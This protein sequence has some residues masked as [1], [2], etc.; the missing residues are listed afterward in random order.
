MAIA[1][2]KS[3]MI[4]NPPR[5]HLHKDQMRWKTTLKPSKSS[6]VSRNGLDVVLYLPISLKSISTAVSLEQV[7]DIP[8]RWFILPEYRKKKYGQNVHEVEFQRSNIDPL[9]TLWTPAPVTPLALFEQAPIKYQP[10]EIDPPTAPAFI[11]PALPPQL[12]RPTP[13]TTSATRLL[14]PFLV[15][16]NTMD[17][18]SSIELRPQQY[19]YPPLTP[20]SPTPVM[21]TKTAAPPIAPVLCSSLPMIVTALAPATISSRLPTVVKP[22]PKPTSKTSFMLPPPTPKLWAKVSTHSKAA[23]EAATEPKDLDCSRCSYE[24][25]RAMHLQAEK[26]KAV[27]TSTSSKAVSTSTSSKAILAPSEISLTL[28]SDIFPVQPGEKAATLPKVSVCLD[29]SRSSLRGPKMKAVTTST[30]A[31]VSPTPSENSS[32]VPM[33]AHPYGCIPS[34]A[35]YSVDEGSVD[36]GDGGAA[37]RILE[38]SPKEMSTAPSGD[39]FILRMPP[40]PEV[41]SPKQQAPERRDL[42]TTKDRSDYPEVSEN[43]TYELNALGD[44]SPGS[45]IPSSSSTQRLPYTGPPG[46]DAAKDEDEGQ[47]DLLDESFFGMTRLPLTLGGMR[48]PM[49]P[50]PTGGTIRAG[51]IRQNMRRRLMK[52]R[53]RPLTALAKAAR[54]IGSPMART[55]AAGSVAT[56]DLNCEFYMVGSSDELNPQDARVDCCFPILEYPK[57]IA[58]SMGSYFYYL[59][60]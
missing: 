29:R 5:V 39:Q 48:F 7:S 52:A 53:A 59:P 27:T 8:Y 1:L 60:Y 35:G 38:R 23:S 33:I 19:C 40:N 2:C 22:T 54:I 3:V 49:T 11:A 56:A 45:T 50:H 13:S 43:I 14:G 17:T 47:D 20:A 57:A 32:P 51:T 26:S 30:N 34:T 44:E 42:A 36:D 37:G 21:T 55:M 41:V 31:K 24:V 28:S 46:N 25:K 18:I 16:D 15:Q 6:R 10:M 9:S 58:W 12:P 4:G